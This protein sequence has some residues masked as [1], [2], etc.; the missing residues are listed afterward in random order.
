MFHIC[1]IRMWMQI[2]NMWQRRHRH[3]IPTVIKLIETSDTSDM[4]GIVAVHVY[5]ERSR[6]F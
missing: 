1:R 2:C 3:A 4:H 5:C 6:C